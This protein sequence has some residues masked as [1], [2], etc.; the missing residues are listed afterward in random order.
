MFVHA[1]ANL[2]VDQDHTVIISGIGCS[3]RITQYLNFDTIHALHGRAIPLA[4][5]IKLVRPEL[6]LVV[7]MGDGDS[8]AIGGNHLIHAARRNIDMTVIIINNMIYGMTGGQ[9]SPTTPEQSKTKT[10]PYGSIEP[11][12]D[13]TKLVIS[14]GATFVAKYTTYHIKG[15]KKGIIKALTHKGFSLLEILSS[16]PV[17]WKMTP[18]QALKGQKKFK[19]IGIITEYDRPEFCEQIHRLCSKQTENQS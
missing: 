12:M 8:V 2:C 16:C 19:S 11:A 15:L 18:S 17:Q 5:G 14:A 4:T 6:N 10:S 7:F 3:G 13:I 1:C 9:F